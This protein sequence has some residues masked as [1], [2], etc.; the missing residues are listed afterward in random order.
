LST[1]QFLLSCNEQSLGISIKFKIHL[2]ISIALIYFNAV[3]VQ[4]LTIYVIVK[5]QLEN[6]K[7]ILTSL[8][9]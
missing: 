4:E 6:Q 5:N 8:R 7:S 1:I 9:A 2:I 3:F